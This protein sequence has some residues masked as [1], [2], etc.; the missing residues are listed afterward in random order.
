MYLLSSSISSVNIR[1]PTFLASTF[2]TLVSNTPND[3]SQAITLPSTPAPNC[4][5]MIEAVGNIFYAVSKNIALGYT[6]TSSCNTYSNNTALSIPDGTGAN[7]PGA[8]VQKTIN[9]PATYGHFWLWS[10]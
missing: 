4:R 10:Q 9:V 3:G 8:T 1:P 7:L 6:F 5:L 2:T